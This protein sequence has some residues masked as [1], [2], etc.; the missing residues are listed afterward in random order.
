MNEKP[1]I[2]V[3]AT[4]AVEC[5][6]RIHKEVGPGLLES[7]YEAL[8]E[9]LLQEQ[10]LRVERQVPV[11]IRCMGLDL[12]EGFRADLVVENRLL[13]E[14]K[15]VEEIAPVH[16]KQVLT[17]LRLL[18]LPLGILINF[19]APTFKSGI[20]RIVNRYEEPKQSPLRV[21]S[22]PAS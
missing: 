11:P 10:G 13:I 16:P 9:K 1:E 14:L 17:Y 15:S 3:L 7:V 22:S 8:F 18:N 21:H 19:G 2:E 6:F 5:G 12:K 4:H 20:K